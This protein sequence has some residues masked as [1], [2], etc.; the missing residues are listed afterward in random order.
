MVLWSEGS[1]RASIGL[2]QARE[3]LFAA[4]ERLGPRKKVLIVPPDATR[5]HSLAGPLAEAAWEYYGQN[6]RDVLPATGTH[7]P[8]TSGEIAAMFGR[9]PAGLFRV[10]DWRRDIATLGT[11]PGDL[12][13]EVSEG[14]IFYDIPMEVNRLVAEGGHDLI[15]SVGQ[16]VPHE[17]AGMAG[18]AKNIF[19]GAGGPGVINRTHFLGAAYGM[20]RIMGRAETPVRRIL[21]YAAEHLAKG[22]PIVH[23]LTVIGRSED[24]RLVLRGLFVGDDDECFRRAAALS[25]EVNVELLDEPL[26]KV[27]VF[28]D[29]REYKSTWLGNKSI[30]RTRMAVAD[31]GEL[32]VLAPGVERFGEDPEID[33]LIRRLGYAGTSMILAE[34]EDATDNW[35]LRNNLGAAAHLI[36]GSTEGR[37]TVTYC[38]GRLTK[39]EVEGVNYRYGDLAAMA[40]RYD[41]AKLAAGFNVLPDGETVF[42]IPNPALGLWAARERFP[43]AKEES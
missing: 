30:Y 3:G 10:H 29:P 11:V 39:A 17:V 23:V 13:Y 43:Q 24:G 31:G 37:F 27:V 26:R 34:V 6:L 7:V 4:L 5:F 15:V 42:F 14:R 8:M 38:P 41:P 36:H 32:V 21:G 9:V 18:H 33:R 28:L 25:V 2:E 12:V 19:V 1:A 35:S 16:V 20:E 22:L 40:K